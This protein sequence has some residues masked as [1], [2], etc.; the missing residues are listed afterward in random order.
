MIEQE[1]HLGHK[2]ETCFSRVPL[3]PLCLIS[4][5]NDDLSRE[6]T[7]DIMICV[8]TDRRRLAGAG[9]SFEGSRRCLIEQARFAA[10]AGVDLIQ[11]RE[12]DLEAA[13]LARLVTDLLEVTH[14]TLTRI[15]VNDRIDV[16]L[17]CGAGGV[18]LR[19]DSVDVADA[20]RLAPAGFLIG[21]SVHRVDE[22]VRAAQAADYL[23]AGTVFPT[24]S[25]PSATARL[26][27]G[28]LQTIVRAV[29]APVLAIGGVAENRIEDI[30]AAGAAGFAAIGC[31]MRPGGAAGAGS[32]VSCRA[33]PLRDLVERARSRFDSVDTGP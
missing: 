20:R 1:G 12:R 18:H 25:K 23:I 10:D 9:A 14:D 21:R 31:F 4:E 17:A 15:I 7:K 2:G 32:A 24:D 3:C 29:R 8:V 27:L 30:R 19:G 26:G 5:A 11:V 16:A 28:G 33:I 22:A 13:E 6:V